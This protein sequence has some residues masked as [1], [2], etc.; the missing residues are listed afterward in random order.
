[1][2]AAIRTASKGLNIPSCFPF[3]SMTRT[4]AALMPSLMRVSV[5]LIDTLRNQDNHPISKLPELK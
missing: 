2:S 1:M 3:S 4:S 5:D